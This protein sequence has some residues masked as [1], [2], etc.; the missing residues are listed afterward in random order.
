M[1]RIWFSTSHLTKN[2]CGAAEGKTPA[3]AIAALLAKVSPE[4]TGVPTIT[5]GAAY[6]AITFPAVGE[7]EE[8]T[9]HLT[10]PHPE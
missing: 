2:A 7:F 1:Y 3:A 4:Y 8:L 5:R 10:G 9:Y 6:C